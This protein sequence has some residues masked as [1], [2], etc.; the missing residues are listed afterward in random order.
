M[1][2]ELEAAV[3]ELI[4][5]LN[6]GAEFA[7]EQAPDVIQQLIFVERVYFVIFAVMTLLGVLLIVPT[8]KLWIKESKLPLLESGEGTF[9]FAMVTTLASAL[10]SIIGMCLSIYYLSAWI[11]PKYHIIKALLQEVN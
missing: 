6:Q 8:I 11:A 1:K 3:T 9:V 10:L 7:I 4:E 5:K 2:K